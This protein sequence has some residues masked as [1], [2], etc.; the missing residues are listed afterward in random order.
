MG[1][2]SKFTTLNSFFTKQPAKQTPVDV[3]D[4]VDCDIVML[5]IAPQTA[6][7]LCLGITASHDERVSNFI[8]QT[9]ADGGG[10]HSVTKI[11][12]TLFN[13][14]YGELSKQR[15]P[16]VDAAQ[17]HKWTFCIDHLRMAIH[18]SKCNK[19]VSAP[20]G[21]DGPHTCKECL[22]MYDSD[23]R[24]K[25]V[26]QKPMPDSANFK[27][28]NEQYQGKSTVERYAKTQGLLEKI[29]DKGCFLY[30]WINSIGI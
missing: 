25:V 23:H 15:K 28:L 24:L 22:I 18:S 17:M 14:K 3:K 13:M 16:Q 30:Y 2:G 10:A 12:N 27:Y 5:D 7:Y 4:M 21:D 9:G 8:T 19:F 20:Q 6:E 26:L 11:A 29:Q 1:G